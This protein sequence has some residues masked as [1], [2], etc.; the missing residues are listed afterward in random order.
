MRDEYTDEEWQ[1]LREHKQRSPLFFRITYA[2]LAVWLVVLVC[3]F[4]WPE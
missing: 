2:F 1:A 4:V 3:L